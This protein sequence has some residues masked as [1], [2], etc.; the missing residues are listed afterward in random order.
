MHIAC[1][2]QQLCAGNMCARDASID[3]TK[4]MEKK[5]TNNETEMPHEQSFFFEW[6]EI[7]II[8]NNYIYY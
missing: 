8:R 7:G 2:R 3:L 6:F 4:W 1:L 5:N